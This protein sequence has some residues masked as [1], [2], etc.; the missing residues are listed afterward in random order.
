MDIPFPVAPVF[1]L[2]LVVAGV[3]PLSMALQADMISLVTPDLAKGSMCAR[4]C[5]VARKSALASK[6]LPLQ[7]A[8]EQISAISLSS[9]GMLSG[10]SEDALDA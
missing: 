5:A 10:V 4:R 1:F 9:P 2:A 6:Q 3:V 8:R 7:N